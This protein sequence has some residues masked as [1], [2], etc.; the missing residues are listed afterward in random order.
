MND[1]IADML[2]R[3]RNAQMVKREEVTTPF[4]KIKFEI[5]KILE[6]EGWI[7]KA[8]KVEKGFG[9]VKIKLKYNEEGGPFIQNMARISKPGRRIYISWKKIP[10]VLNNLGVAIIST[11][12]GIM[13]GQEAK[14]RKLGGE[15]ICEIY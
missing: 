12:Q 15:L 2:T 8:E 9:E 14:K 10:I 13:T 4:S 7:S 11:S 1:P 6:K 5:A 3:I